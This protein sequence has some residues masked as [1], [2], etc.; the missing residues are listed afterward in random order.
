MEIEV[1]LSSIE[2][3]KRAEEAGATRLELTTAME[4]LGVTPSI[5]NYI[6]AKEMTDLPILAYIRP[7][8]GGFVYSDLEYDVIVRDAMNF[9]QHGARDF[10]IGMLTED[11]TVDS[12]RIADLMSRLGSDCNFTFHKAFDYVRDFDEAANTLIDLGFTRILTSGGPSSTLDNLDILKH[13]IE[14]YSDRIEVMPGGGINVDNV[15]EVLDALNITSI[16]LSAKMEIEDDMNYIATDVEHL[17]QVVS[18]IN[19]KK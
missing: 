6:I 4:V 12:L 16:H 3:V 11:K 5:S 8:A 10:V 19:A 7:R 1:C 2:D 9:Y 17:K 14:T 18:I 15:Q 13:L